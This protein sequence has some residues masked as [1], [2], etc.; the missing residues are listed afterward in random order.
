MAAQTRILKISF[1]HGGSKGSSLDILPYYK[2]CIVS[3]HSLLLNT[4]EVTNRIAWHGL[5]ER[6]HLKDVTKVEKVQ[7]GEHQCR[8]SK[9][10]KFGLFDKRE[11][12]VRIFRYFPNVNVVFKC[13]SWTKNKFVLKWFSGYFKFV[14][15]KFFWEREFPR[16]KMFL[17]SNFSQL[18]QRRGGIK[19]SI[20]PN[21]KKVQI[22]WGEG[23]Q[24]N[25]GIY[26]HLESSW[27]WA[28]K[29]CS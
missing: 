17:I 5:R 23:G 9:Q 7:K 8:K 21:F 16:F 4:W 20:F 29:K 18:G 27:K 14:K 3:Y 11:G 24:E 1:F 22:V 12:G 19:F 10:S 13:F 26:P 6:S 25:C 28:E 2:R 15:L